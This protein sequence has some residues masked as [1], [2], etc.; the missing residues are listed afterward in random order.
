MLFKTI[1][2]FL[3]LMESLPTYTAQLQPF[4]KKILALK[5]KQPYTS[6]Y[7]LRHLSKGNNKTNR[8]AVG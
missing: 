4:L 1:M 8:F 2:S 7:N 3:S 6:I 5:K